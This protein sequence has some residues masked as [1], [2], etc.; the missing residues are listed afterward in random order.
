ML[1]P[2]R[3]RSAPASLSLLVVSEPAVVV[4]LTVALL[5]FALL[6]LDEHASGSAQT[7]ATLSTTAAMDRA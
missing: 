7:P 5:P 6:L 1:I 3:G 2:L 4:A